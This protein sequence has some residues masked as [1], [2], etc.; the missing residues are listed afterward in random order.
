MNKKLQRKVLGRGLSALIPAAVD[1]AIDAERAIVDIDCDGIT[2]NPFQPREDF[3]DEEI[4][5]LAASINMQGLLQPI[6]VRRNNN[7]EFQIVSGERR[8]RAL[9]LLGRQSVPC[10]VRNKLSDREMMELALV[11]NIQREDLNEIEKAEAY[12]RLITEH[13]YTHEELSAQLGKSRAAITNT[14][15]LR[16]L[17]EEVQQLVRK[18]L[19]TM[20]HARALLALEKDEERIA[21]ARKIVEEDLPVREIEKRV[22]APEHEKPQS[23]R[24]AAE[25]KLDP[26]LAEALSRLQYRLGTNVGVK[27]A[28]GERGTIKIEYYSDKDLTRIFDLL[29]PA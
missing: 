9:K 18:N 4:K 24:N 8:F 20:G 22:R 15:R 11:E 16:T 6:L 23:K 25:K 29:L 1:D 5:N 13:N 2:P 19:L 14:L 3:N 10:I 12:Q 28:D 27:S 26:D 17:P 21:L 7:N